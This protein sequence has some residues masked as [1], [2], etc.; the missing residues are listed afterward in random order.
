[1]NTIVLSC[2][3]PFIIVYGLLSAWRGLPMLD[4]E[5]LILAELTLIVVLFIDALQ[6]EKRRIH[7]EHIIPIRLQ[8]IGLPL[9]RR[10][11]IDK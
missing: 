1:L 7:S 4:A 2:V 8:F 3:A 6:N 10:Q 11:Q 5:A 9:Y